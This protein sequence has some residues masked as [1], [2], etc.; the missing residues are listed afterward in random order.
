MS[1]S[2]DSAHTSITFSVRHMMISN[3]HGR[4]ENVEGIVDFN[5]E[6]PGESNI[7][8]KIDASSINTR[9][10]QRDDHLHSPDF[11]DVEKYPY[12][13]FKSTHIEKTGPSGEK[14]WI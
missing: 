12:I 4:F 5:P 2:I 8:V 14:F 3:V 7:D 9:E 13:L 1:W 11:L 10:P 6:Y